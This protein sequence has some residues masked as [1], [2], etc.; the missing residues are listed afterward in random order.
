MSTGLSTTFI[1]LIRS[2]LLRCREF[3]NYRALR[4]VFVTDDL[5]PFRI[6]LREA[7]NPGA[8]VDMNLEYLLEQRLKGGRPV[9]PIFVAALRDHYEQ[10][11]AM[12]EDLEDL[13][14]QVQAAM[15][16]SVSPPA[17][18]M[19]NQKLFDLLLILDFGEQVRLAKQVIQS[20]PVAAFLVHGEPECGQRLLATRLARLSPGWQTAQLLTIDAGSNGTGKSSR[21]LWRQVACKLGT[22]TTTAPT[23]I[24]EKVCAWLQTQDVIFIFQT[25]DYMPPLLLLEW[26]RDFWQ[27]LAARARAHIS[28]VQ[29]KTHL[30]LFMVD[31]TGCV[32]DWNIPLDR[33]FDPNAYIGMPL[34]LPPATRFTPDVI[35][36]WLDLADVLPTGLS[37]QALTES[38]DNG[39]P[40]LVYDRI[41][42]HCG[43]SWEGDLARWLL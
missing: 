5:R 36:F 15:S 12:R 25:V 3:E 20:Q 7:D 6:G 16:R 39:K 24:A 32:C 9:F 14:S 40:Q 31:Y 43:V 22:P 41:C 21:S 8:L 26:M 33:Q 34:H 38:C 18:P 42:T 30:L 11:D 13:L 1:P 23:E 10:G 28:T 35:S 19:H 37:T 17:A 27:S 4:A 2:V 29:S